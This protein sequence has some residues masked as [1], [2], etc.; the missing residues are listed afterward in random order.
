MF[1]GSDWCGGPHTALRLSSWPVV[2]W[3]KRSWLICQSLAFETCV[4][5]FKRSCF[6]SDSEDQLPEFW[7]K[8]VSL[9]ALLS[10]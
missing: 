4:I 5:P 8:W 6:I 7:V 10:E 9:E 1:W 3:S 2:G